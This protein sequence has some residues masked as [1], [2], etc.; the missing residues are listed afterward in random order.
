MNALTL[1]SLKDAH[2]APSPRPAVLTVTQDLAAIEAE[3][4]SFETQAR[5]SFYQT[6]D[7]CRLWLETVGRQRHVEP[8]IV[9]GRA[10]DGRLLFLLP[11]AIRRD[12]GC[13]VLEWLTTGELGYGYGLYS[14]CF[15]PQAAQWFAGEGWRIA[16]LAGPVDALLLRDMPERLHGFAHPLSSWFSFR[17]RNRSYVMSLADGFE[18]VH[19]RKRSAGS[20][21]GQKKRDAKLAAFGAVEFGLPHDREEL[22]LQIDE[23]F[24]QQAARLAEAGVRGVH[25]PAEREMI[26][27]L[28]DVK[29]AA[30][31]PYRLTIGGEMAAMMLGGNYGGTYWALIS[32]LGNGPARRF[33]PGDAALRRTIEA[34]CARG[35]ANF[36]FSS[37]DTSYKSHWADE[38][39]DLHEIVR[40]LT[41]KGYLWALGAAAAILAKRMIKRS[42]VLWF[43]VSLLRRT[44]AG[45]PRGS[46]SA[47]PAC[48]ELLVGPEVASG[49]H[50]QPI[51][52]QNGQ[53][54]QSVKRHDG[55]HMMRGVERHVPAEKANGGGSEGRARIDQ[56]VLDQRTGGVLG[57][58]KRAQERLA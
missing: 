17:G 10:A 20:R 52:Q 9:L 6:Y 58:Q 53:G 38:V 32:S 19:A 5:G 35:L 33:S 48:P 57:K 2:V 42:P 21:R 27:R 25:G 30:L 18:A 34:C 13:R 3:W 7:W 26:H 12:R 46:W 49:R 55:Q 51:A 28:A 39:I 43:G 24:E 11:F 44:L 4:R 8:R 16:E 36:D 50:A 45:A 1:F 41:F 23:M 47:T 15:L 40:G 29:G 37:G 31:L 54:R 56:H 14:P 22:H